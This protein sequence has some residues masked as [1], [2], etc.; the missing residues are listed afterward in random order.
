MTR[1]VPLPDVARQLTLE[2][3]NEHAELLTRTDRKYIVET[4]VLARLLAANADQLAVLDIDGR[5]EF[6][7]ESVYFDTSDLRLYRDAA[8]SRRIRF[9]VRTRLYRDA[10][11][12]VLEVKAKDGRGQTIKSR[13]DYCVED[14]HHLTRAAQEFVDELARCP[15]I[16]ATLQPVLTTQ[17]LRST[18]VD[19]TPGAR[20]TIDRGL[21]C[22]EPAGT[23]I[24]LDEA[25]IETKSGGATSAIDRW[26]WKQ[27]VRP[28]RISKYCT[29]L[30][31]MRP[32]LPANKWHRTLARHFH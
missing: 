30:A 27:G 21:V 5:R 31:A 7:Y 22:T 4:G 15:G 18:F 24:G 28:V 19:M 11:V 3:L 12:A 29:A 9:K 8:T 32:E 2:Q 26:L 14:R 20:Y 6:G 10:D 1:I 16:G 23:A 17:Y 25:I 13:L